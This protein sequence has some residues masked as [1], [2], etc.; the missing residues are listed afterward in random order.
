MNIV[1]FNIFV[2]TYFPCSSSS[3]Y[4]WSKFLLF[5]FLFFFLHLDVFFCCCCW[6]NYSSM[7]NFIAFVSFFS[8]HHSLIF[9][10]VCFVTPL[11]L[12]SLW[13]SS[14][15]LL[16]SFLFF[17]FLPFHNTQN[18][19]SS[20]NRSFWDSESFETF[21]PEL[22]LSLSVKVPEGFLSLFFLAFVCFLFVCLFVFCWI[23]AG[24]LFFLFL[25][26]YDWF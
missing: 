9:H 18:I 14:L 24:L 1:F 12:I 26:C 10:F 4:Y 23:L 19:L 2:I 5:S 8:S 17:L 22:L 7:Y 15:R 25:F 6:I 20:S 11:F 16:L 13:S 21:T 3:V